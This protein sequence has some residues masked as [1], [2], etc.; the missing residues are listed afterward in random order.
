MLEKLGINCENNT[1][2]EKFAKL[3]EY[4][5]FIEYYLDE[6]CSKEDS[7]VIILSGKNKFILL[8]KKEIGDELYQC[9]GIESWFLQGFN[10]AINLFT[11]D[12]L[13]NHPMVIKINELLLF[14]N[15]SYRFGQL[16]KQTS[17]VTS[18]N[19]EK[20]NL[21]M[22]E[23]VIKQEE[24]SSSYYDNFKDSFNIFNFQLLMIT[25]VPV[26]LT[27]IYLKINKIT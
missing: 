21:I 26:L 22:N 9:Y 5:T 25:T 8:K 2:F 19:R 14:S 16:L 3:D 18:I 11:L 15:F 24:Q 12:E 10:V 27:M 17:T 13:K 20:Y 6:K 4:D 7:D 1:C 23:V